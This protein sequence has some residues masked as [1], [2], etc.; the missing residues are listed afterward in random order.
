MPDVSASAN[1]ALRLKFQSEKQVD[2]LLS[3]LMPEA[4]APPTH[5]SFVKLQKDGAYLVL[6]VKA[7]DTVAL[8]ATVNAY[9]RWINSI[10]NVIETVKK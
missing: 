1:V 8:R 7:E 4:E 10:L 2:T 5:R 6:A 9:L 3:A